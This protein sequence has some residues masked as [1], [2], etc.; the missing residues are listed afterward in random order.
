MLLYSAVCLGVQLLLSRPLLMRPLRLVNR[1]LTR[2]RDGLLALQ[3]VLPPNLH[4]PKRLTELGIT[5]NQNEKEDRSSIRDG[6]CK[7][8]RERKVRCSNRAPAGGMYL[9]SC[10]CE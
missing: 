2:L 9:E 1:L 4:V 7:I 5:N 3:L 6:E 8:S 10:W